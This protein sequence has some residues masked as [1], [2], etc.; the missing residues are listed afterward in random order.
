[1]T[2]VEMFLAEC[3]AKQ[4]E[5]RNKFGPE[6]VGRNPMVEFVEEMAD[7]YNYLEWAEALNGDEV[8]DLRRDVQEIG[9]RAMGRVRSI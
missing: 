4:R 2:E 5:G 8:S 1:V 6:S 7:A 9:A 3:D